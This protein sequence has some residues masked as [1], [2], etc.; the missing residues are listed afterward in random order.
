M[1]KR[2]AALACVLL[3]TGACSKPI[4]LKQAL[5]VTDVSTGWWDAGV[6]NGQNKLVPSVTFT[7]RRAQGADI[8]SASLNVMFKNLQGEVRDE[9]YIQRVDFGPNGVT[10]PITVHAENGH[11]ADPPQ[12]R[13]DMLKN[14]QFQDVDVEVLARG[15]A[16]QWTP[17]HKERVVRTLLAH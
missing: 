2:A 5:Q 4:D 7:L 3:I 8:S 17:L 10:A 9:K 13:L 1:W 6:V 14:S 12:T 16:A 15:S 11:T